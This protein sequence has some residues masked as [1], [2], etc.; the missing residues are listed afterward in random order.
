M[1]NT[2][3]ATLLTPPPRF[4]ASGDATPAGS[5]AVAE[6]SLRTLI[7]NVPFFQTW[8][9]T[10]TAA[11]A[12]LHIYVGEV[13]NPIVSAKVVN[14]LATIAL[15]DPHTMRVADTP[16]IEGASLGAQAGLTLDGLQTITAV[17]AS[18]FSFSTSAED[19]DTVYLDDA[20]V[21]PWGRPMAVIGKASGGFNKE[22][23]GTGGAVIGNGSLEILLEADVSST[24]AT[25]PRNAEVEAQNAVGQFIDGLMATQETGDLMFLRTAELASGPTLTTTTQQD[26]STKRF[27]RWFAQINVSWGLSG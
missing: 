13:G 7:A 24:F 25:D 23:I 18:G 22:S 6:D 21:L 8:T 2:F 26:D 16:T 10:S 20:F 11:D 15:R 4:P 1:G 14:G 3:T 5:I 9:G 27:E 12:L 17:T 19:A